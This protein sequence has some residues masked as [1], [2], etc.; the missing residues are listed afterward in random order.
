MIKLMGKKTSTNLR[1]EFVF[2]KTYARSYN[3]ERFAN[4]KKYLTLVYLLFYAQNLCL[5]KPMQD[6]T[7]WRD[8]K[9]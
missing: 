7:I 2:I 6:L 8:L 1:S 4:L 9:I 5:S 3:L